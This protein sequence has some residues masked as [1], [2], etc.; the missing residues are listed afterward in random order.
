MPKTILISHSNFMRIHLRWSEGKNVQNLVHSIWSCTPFAAAYTPPFLLVSL[1]NSE[2][3]AWKPLV[4]VFE[5]ARMANFVR[6]GLL[7][8]MADLGT[9]VVLRTSCLFSRSPSVSRSSPSSLSFTANAQWF[10]AHASS[11]YER[12]FPFFFCGFHFYVRLKCKLFLYLWTLHKVYNVKLLNSFATYDY[13][14]VTHDI[15]ICW[16]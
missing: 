11:A 14:A 6:G 5:W 8:N 3:L 15:I 9:R 1:I 2:W 16:I 10:A 12:N 13:H 7:R 4:F